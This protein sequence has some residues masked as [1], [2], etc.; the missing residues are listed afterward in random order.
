[1]VAVRASGI[2]RLLVAFQ[3]APALSIREDWARKL[4]DTLQDEFPQFLGMPLIERDQ[5]ATFLRPAREDVPAQAI[6]QIVRQSVEVV[7]ERPSPEEA[8][9]FP[10]FL[11]RLYQLS[12]QI[13]HIGRVSRVGRVQQ[14][15]YILDSD[16]DAA[17]DALRDCLTKLSPEEA[18]DVQLQ[19]SV[20]EDIFNVN[21]ALRTAASSNE[22]GPAGL[23]FRDT[24]VAQS[25]VNNWDT[26]L[27]VDWTM[28]ERVL[29]R[30]ARH[31]D[32]D[33]PAFLQVRLGLEVQQ[34]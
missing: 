14:T 16:S 28:A 17:R 32:E 18:D 5:F 29:T 20:R 23:P 25:D 24:L 21:L 27:D 11:H 1:M 9:A 8:R 15:G 2:G 33:V 7:L 34:G 31:A 10:P 12:R 30:G 13:F 26:S 19:F 22:P 3:V 4:F 6:C